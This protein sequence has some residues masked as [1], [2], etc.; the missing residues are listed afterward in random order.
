[1]SKRVAA[2]RMGEMMTLDD[3]PDH[4]SI[5][6]VTISNLNM[7]RLKTG[8]RLLFRVIFWYILIWMLFILFYI[9]LYFLFIIIYSCL[10]PPC[11]HFLSFLYLYGC[12]SFAFRS[13]QCGTRA[14]RPDLGSVCS[15]RNQRYQSFLSAGLWKR[16]GINHLHQHH[17]STCIL[18]TF[19]QLVIVQ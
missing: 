3:I 9:I 2:V 19:P 12:M 13:S 11:G 5:V 18:H 7:P 1:M 4:I 14:S 17:A 8:A 10:R 16:E 6:S 15:T